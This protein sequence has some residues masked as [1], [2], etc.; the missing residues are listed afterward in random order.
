[1]RVVAVI[2]MTQIVSDSATLSPRQMVM[3]RGLDQGPNTVD[4]PAFSRRASSATSPV[5][6]RSS[7]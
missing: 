1:M 6:E 4:M 2:E 7:R 5:N 3:A